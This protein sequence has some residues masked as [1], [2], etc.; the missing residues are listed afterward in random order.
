MPDVPINIQTTYP[1]QPP[2]PQQIPLGPTFISPAF[3]SVGPAD[4]TAQTAVNT[5]QSFG[6]VTDFLNLVKQKLTDRDMWKGIGLV[7]GA[8]A[9]GVIGIL[10]LVFNPTPKG[11]AKTAIKAAVL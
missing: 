3:P 9:L 10:I 4:R 1:S 8:A 5:A 11:T 6:S 2:L 7:A